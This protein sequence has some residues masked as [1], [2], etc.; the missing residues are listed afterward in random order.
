MV[1]Q[2]GC[3]KKKQNFL[4][5]V[6]QSFHPCCH[7]MLPGNIALILSSLHRKQLP[8]PYLCYLR[9][10]QTL[11]R[12]RPIQFLRCNHFLRQTEDNKMW[13][14]FFL[15]FHYKK[16]F[17]LFFLFLSNRTAVV[18]GIKGHFCRSRLAMIKD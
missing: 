12:S 9:T 11:L 16:S 10:P 4:P 14:M 3:T 7:R 8:G 5:L 6:S 1:A 13:L 2:K 17:Y 15:Y 18:I